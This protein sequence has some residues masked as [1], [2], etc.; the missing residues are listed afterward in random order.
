MHIT[1]VLPGA[2]LSGGIRVIAIY[3]EKLAQRGHQVLVVHPWP[4]EPKLR[5]KVRCLVRGQGWPVPHDRRPTHF[6]GRPVERKILDGARHLTDADVPDADV[7]V[8]T[9]WETAEWIEPLSSRKGVKVFF[10]QGYEVFDW[11][12]IERVKATWAKPMHKIVVSQ[13]LA[14][15]ARDEY[16][17][18]EVALVPN[19]VDTQ[20]FNAPVRGKQAIPTVGLLYGTESIKGADVAFRAFELAQ[21]E[22]PGL[23]LR[24][25]GSDLPRRGEL[26]AVGTHFE[27]RPAQHRLREIYGGCDAWL[28]ASRNDGFG[29]PLVEAM[30]CR[31]PIIATPTGAAPELTQ[32]GGGLMVSMDDAEDMARAICQV[33][34]MPDPEWRGLSARAH[35]IA[36]THSWD[37]AADQF[38]AALQRACER[39]AR[40]HLAQRNE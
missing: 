20:Q 19:A 16:G 24:V 31:T 4:P 8:A 14:K 37:R 26:P 38:A 28:F 39:G 17:D 21:R 36:Q 3:A 12:P 23:R 27:L 29:L 9:W 40:R 22:H 10:A 18:H 33:V 13:W 11:L 1:F 32:A 5:D 30:A 34:D 35:A 2:N 15:V 7:V 6:D 25:F